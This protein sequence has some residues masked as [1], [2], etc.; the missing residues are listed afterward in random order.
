MLI[1]KGLTII[2]LDLILTLTILFLLPGLPG[3]IRSWPF[4]SKVERFND[5]KKQGY[6]NCFGFIDDWNTP[7][8]L[9]IRKLKG[10]VKEYESLD[11]KKK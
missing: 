3:T 5:L 11:I 7:A 9:I 10:F 1:L 4:T 8:K 6:D 2:S